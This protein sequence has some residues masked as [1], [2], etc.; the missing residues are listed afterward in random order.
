MTAKIIDGRAIAAGI[1]ALTAEK[2]AAFTA[3]QGRAP[4]L[5]VI[6]VGHHAPSEIYVRMKAKAAE[7]AGINAVIHRYDETASPADIEK[8]IA[9][10]NRDETV[11]GI[12][13]Q[14]PLPAGWPTVKILNRIAPAKDVDGLTILNSGRR[15]MGLPC[16]LPCTPKGAMRLIKSVHEDLTGLQALVIGRSDL[17]GKPMAQLLLAEN[18]T[19]TQA[20]SRTRDLASL[21]GQADILVVA[22]GRP[23][24]VKGEWIKPGAIVIDVGINRPAE[25]VIVG[26]VDFADASEHAGYITPV[27]GGVGPM[28]V[29]CLLENC[30]TQSDDNIDV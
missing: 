16:H 1:N 8:I 10:L 25:G 17:V 26:D 23:G 5:A 22:A 13:L 12:L 7:K 9:E 20:H 30:V 29:A 18:C 4:G 6:L 19:V 3:A 24:L 2:A 21:C 15:G 14:L 11:Q 27:P 28:T